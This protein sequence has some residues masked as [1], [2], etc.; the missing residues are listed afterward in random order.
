MFAGINLKPGNFDEDRLEVRRR[1]EYLLG[2]VRSQLTG[3]AAAA[4]G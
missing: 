3:V 1:P 4:A 2:R